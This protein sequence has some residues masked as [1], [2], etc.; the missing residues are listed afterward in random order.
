MQFLNIIFFLQY[1][2]QVGEAKP[3]PLT[4]RMVNQFLEQYANCRTCNLAIGLRET[5]VI[6]QVTR[7]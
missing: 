7:S 3:T 2:Y 4:F 6:I 5:E 1:K